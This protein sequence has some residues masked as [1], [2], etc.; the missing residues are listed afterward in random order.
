MCWYRET[1]E[2]VIFI[3]TLKNQ[4]LSYTL[5]IYE[6]VLLWL[7]QSWQY[8]SVYASE[9]AMASLQPHILIFHTHHGIFV[10]NHRL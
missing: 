8:K 7:T 4:S 2:S 10:N 1:K 6:T 3:P 9:N 5:Y